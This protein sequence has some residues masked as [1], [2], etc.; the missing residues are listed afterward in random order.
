VQTSAQ[1]Q[2]YYS[3]EDLKI[4][5]GAC[6]Y[7]IIFTINDTDFAKMISESIGN[8]TRDKKSETSQAVK[9]FGSKNKS[10]EG[11][12][13][14][15]TQDLMNIPN[16][17]VI[18]SVFGH[19]ATPIKGKINYYFKNRLFKKIVKKYSKKEK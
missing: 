5:S 8:F 12:A 15:T 17:E 18:I 1:V 7:N 9:I 2:K 11:Y 6:A 10:D 13:L 3:L 19:K 4:I 14:L 16:D